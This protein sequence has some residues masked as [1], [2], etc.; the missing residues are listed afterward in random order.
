[1][2]TTLKIYSNKITIRIKRRAGEGAKLLSM[3]KHK[4]HVFLQP[5]SENPLRLTGDRDHRKKYLHLNANISK[6]HNL[7][8]SWDCLSTH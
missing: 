2:E 8:G 5:R 6:I 1:M 3:Y 4:I 7:I